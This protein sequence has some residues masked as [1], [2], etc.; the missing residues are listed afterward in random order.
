MRIYSDLC[1]RTE[2]INDF[3]CTGVSLCAEEGRGWLTHNQWQSPTNN[4]S[5]TI[6]ALKAGF[7]TPPALYHPD[8]VI[9]IYYT[10]A[11]WYTRAADERIRVVLPAE[12]WPFC[13]F[14]CHLEKERGGVVGVRFC[15]KKK[16]E[17]K[18]YS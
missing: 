17:K 15:E 2:L 4:P 14:N 18:L 1:T 10:F 5:L 7:H 3:C 11:L 12:F 16:N 6:R 9:R 8:P 13:K